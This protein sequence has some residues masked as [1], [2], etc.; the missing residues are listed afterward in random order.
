MKQAFP[1]RRPFTG[2]YAILLGLFMLQLLSAPFFE[3][4]MVAGYVADILFYLFLAAAA[5]SIQGSRFFKITLLLGFAAISVEFVNFFLSR[6]TMLLVIGSFISATYLVLVMFA[7]TLDVIREPLTIRTDNVMG[8]L[9]VYVIIGIFWTQLFSTLDLVNPAAFDYG[10]HGPAL[11]LVRRYS[12]LL[13]YS[14]VTLLTIGF[15]DVI[16]VSSMAQTL[17]VIEGLIGQF[18][19]VFFM[20]SLVGVYVSSQSRKD[21]LKKNDEP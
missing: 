7:I 15:G 12:L 18:Y 9:C 5:Y 4:T 13:Y 3:G 10:I 21:V 14:F 17:T 8:G 1:R 2:R 16:P 6:S 19:L 20:A 11:G